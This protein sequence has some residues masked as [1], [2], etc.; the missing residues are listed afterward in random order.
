MLYP[1]LPMIRKLVRVSDKNDLL[2]DDYPMFTHPIIQNRQL[3]DQVK[4]IANEHAPALTDI[5]KLSQ[6]EKC[7]KISRLV[8]DSTTTQMKQLSSPTDL[9]GVVGN[10]CKYI[11]Q[12]LYKPLNVRELAEHFGI[13][14][15]YLA[16]IFKRKLG[17]SP[18]QYIRHQRLREAQN[19]V[20]KGLPFV[21]I[22]T[23]LWFADQAHFSREFKRTTGIT[24]SNIVV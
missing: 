14:R 11:E 20:E 3:F 7:E 24:P 23:E 6:D 9:G 15:W 2:K 12:N 5:H 17:L 16:R 10:T 22:A 21:Q 1:T 8:L 4:E 18:N 13:S 19:L